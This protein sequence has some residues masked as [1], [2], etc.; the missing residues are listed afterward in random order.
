MPRSLNKGPLNV[1]HTCSPSHCLNFFITG[2]YAK[3]KNGLQS[4]HCSIT[5]KQYSVPQIST[6]KSM[7]GKIE[8]QKALKYACGQQLNPNALILWKRPNRG[9]EKS[10]LAGLNF[11]LSVIITP[12]KRSYGTEVSVQSPTC[13]CYPV[14][15]FIIIMEQ[16]CAGHYNPS[17]CKNCVHV[18]N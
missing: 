1:L 14:V 17:I 12:R 3:C 13:T 16:S 18:V 15:P 6:P 9:L 11:P 4:C 2:R 8:D 10:S 5:P 7:A